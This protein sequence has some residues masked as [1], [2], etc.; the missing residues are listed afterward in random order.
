MAPQRNPLVKLAIEI[1]PLAA[2]FLAYA[3]G[4]LYIATAV[5]MVA[6]AIALLAGW[7]IERRVAIMPVVSLIVVTVFGGLTLLL[8]DETFIKMK[9][10]IVNGLFAAVLFGGLAFG[11]PLLRPVLGAALQLTEE[12]WRR[13]SWR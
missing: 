10:T 12:G 11:R 9:P 4:D 6:A 3:R 8:H 7:L 1:G 5:F 2:F 13:L